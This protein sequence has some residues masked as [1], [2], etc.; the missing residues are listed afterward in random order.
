MGSVD[1]RQEVSNLQTEIKALRDGA[2]DEDQKNK[3]IYALTGLESLQRAIH[4]KDMIFGVEP[5]HPLAGHGNVLSP[6]EYLLRLNDESGAALPPYPMI[7]AFYD[8]GLTAEIDLILFLCGLWQFG[9][10]DEK[11]VTINISAK[12]LHSSKFIKT[13]LKGLEDAGLKPG[14]PEKIIAEIHESTSE[15]MSPHVLE[16]FRQFGGGFAIDDVG[17]SMK[18]VMRLSE[19]AEMADYI[20][21]DRHSVCADPDEPTS[22]GQVMAFIRSLLPGAVIVA[23]GVKTTEHAQQIHEIFPD[24][25]YVQGLYLPTRDVFAKEW[26]A[27][28]KISA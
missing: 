25:Q 16:L 9:Q 15:V 23:E 12:S 10:D 1:L 27:L 22:L 14:G 26:A 20:K 24:I 8:N 13:A 28:T 17:L 2:K 11:Q 3:F 6:G 4:N 21:I 5:W 18:D 19:F 7:M